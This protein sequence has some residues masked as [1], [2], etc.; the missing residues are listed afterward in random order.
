MASLLFTLPSSQRERTGLDIDLHQ[1]HTLADLILRFGDL[2]MDLVS[3]R[4]AVTWLEISLQE[5]QGLIDAGASL[6][7]CLGCSIELE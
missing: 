4:V 7:N 6:G 2:R 5:R 3:K 1:T